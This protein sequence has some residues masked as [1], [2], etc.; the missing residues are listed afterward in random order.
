MAMAEKHS[1][2][3]WRRSGQ[4]I[5]YGPMVAGDGFCVAIVSRDPAEAEANMAL[6]LAAPRLLAACKE[7]IPDLAHYVAK[8]GPGPD[9]RLDDLRAAIAQ[10]E[11]GGE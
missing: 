1:P 9:R 6:L 3:P 2:A 10:A 7:A 5:E 8:H 11:G 4:R